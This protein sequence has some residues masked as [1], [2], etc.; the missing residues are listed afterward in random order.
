VLGAGLAGLCAAYRLIRSGF[1]V[2]VLEAQDRPGGRVQTVRDGFAGGGFAEAGAVR[3]PNSHVHTNRYLAEFG[4]TDKLFAYPDTGSQL[5]YLDGQRFATPRPPET[6]S[7]ARMS[8]DEARDPHAGFDRY[9][10]P[11]VLAA[12]DVSAPRWP[13]LAGAARPPQRRQRGLAALP[14][15]QLGQPRRVQRA[16]LRRPGDGDGRG[17]GGVRAARRQRPAAGRV[18]RRAGRP[19]AL[20]GRGA[21]GGQPA[22]PGGGRLPGRRRAASRGRGRLRG[23]HDP[24]PG[25][26]AGPAGRARRAQDAGRAGVPDGRRGEG[27]LPDQEQVL[28]RPLGVRRAG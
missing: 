9:L 28:A 17:N 4:L 8:D 22:G 21:A 27:V 18:R 1:E 11:A 15:G 19:G 25:A 2:V 3:I 16:G 12:G 14:A 7:V 5:W 10:G 20:P 26:A 6:W 24:V 13:D 23:V